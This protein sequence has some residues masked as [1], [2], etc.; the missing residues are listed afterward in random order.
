[1]KGPYLI[2]LFAVGLLITG[3]LLLFLITRPN[4]SNVTLATNINWKELSQQPNRIY[5]GN[6]NFKIRCSDCHGMNGKGS[7][8]APNLTDNEWLNGNG[9]F[10]SIYSI[11]ANG[12]PNGLMK[13][14][15][16]KLFEKDLIN[17][18]LYVHQ[19]RSKNDTP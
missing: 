9:S 16:A 3:S 17:L 5:S 13:G 10:E 7:K 1:M 14:W 8:Q 2:L 4:H 12:S 18:T 6:V 19:L 11:I 15:K